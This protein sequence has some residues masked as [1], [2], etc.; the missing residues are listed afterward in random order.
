MSETNAT[1]TIEGDVAAA[2]EEMVTDDASENSNV[3]ADQ[4]LITAAADVI[5]EGIGTNEVV[6]GDV[7]SEVD[8]TKA[9]TNEADSLIPAEADPTISTDTVPAGGGAISGG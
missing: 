5:I 4:T 7:V 8:T 1:T 2:N 6:G 9:V 3:E